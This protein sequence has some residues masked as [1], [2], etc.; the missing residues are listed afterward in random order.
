M[1][2]MLNVHFVLDDAFKDTLTSETLKLSC[3]MDEPEER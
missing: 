3:C 1:H 2:N